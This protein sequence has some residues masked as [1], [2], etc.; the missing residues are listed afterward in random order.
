MKTAIKSENDDEDHKPDSNIY[1]IKEEGAHGFVKIEQHLAN[2]TEDFKDALAITGV[3]SE[4]NGG[5][6]FDIKDECESSDDFKLEVKKEELSEVSERNLFGLSSTNWSIIRSPTF[7]PDVSS[8]QQQMCST[9][10]FGKI[11]M[12][13]S[14]TFLEKLMKTYST[15]WGGMSCHLWWTTSVN[16]PEVLSMPHRSLRNSSH[17]SLDVLS[18]NSGPSVPKETSASTIPT[19]RELM[20]SACPD[21]QRKM[22]LFGNMEN[23]YAKPSI[24]NISK[25][26]GRDSTSNEKSAQLANDDCQQKDNDINSQ[27]TRKVTDTLELHSSEVAEVDEDEDARNRKISVE[28][29]AEDHTDD[30]KVVKNATVIQEEHVEETAEDGSV[31]RHTDAED[32]QEDDK[33]AENSRDSIYYDAQSKNDFNNKF[34]IEDSNM[35]ISG[36]EDYSAQCISKSPKRSS[37]ISPSHSPSANSPSSKEDEYED[38]EMSYET[39][40]GQN[41][42]PACSSDNE[43]DGNAL[44]LL[45]SD[46]SIHTISI[47]AAIEAAQ[48]FD[49]DESLGNITQTT[50]KS[51]ENIDGLCAKASETESSAIHTSKLSN[52]LTTTSEDMQTSLPEKEIDIGEASVKSSMNIGED[53]TKLTKVEPIPLKGSIMVDYKQNPLT[54]TIDVGPQD[55][56]TAKLKHIS[57]LATEYANTLKL[58]QDLLKAD[59]VSVDY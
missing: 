47:S 46:N 58:A 24:Q 12:K 15:N 49:S 30:H 41:G 10:N 45:G 16:E 42:S 50:M 2:S 13:P 4:G 18:T 14:N 54:V 23:V 39:E 53:T 22:Q 8:L 44:H 17:K 57:T 33:S 21:K 40:E 43:N 20:T 29:N 36:N 56:V 52:S 3:K 31:I 37:E 35:H 28:T 48:V 25:V 1:S 9:V 59:S 32:R 5:I 34:K 19:L 6:N 11:S 7:I 26:A 27:V 51:S 55:S 38:D